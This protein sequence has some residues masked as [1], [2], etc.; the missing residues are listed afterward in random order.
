M[1]KSLKVLMIIILTLIITNFIQAQN[2]KVT[3]TVRDETTGESLIGANI[4]IPDLNIGAVTNTEGFYSIENVKVG[5]YQV[6]VSYIGYLKQNKNIKISGNTKLNFSLEP[7]SVLLDETVVKGTRAVLR[8][9]PVAFSEIKGEELEFRLA[10]RDIPQ[11]LATTPSV[12]S[13]VSGGGAGDANLYV[14]GVSQRNVAVMV[15]GVPVNDMENKWVYWSNWA[16][17]GD[18]LDETQV[19]RGIGASPYSVNAVGGVMNM[20][21]IGVGSEEEYLK[22]RSQYGSN[23]LIKGSLAFHKKLNSLFCD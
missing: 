12:Y 4:F 5:T 15:N 2:Y 16:G 18:V 19:Q 11:E 6:T 14:R 17:L 7:S 3:G 10:S 21:T 13:S 9:T 1:N 8:E 20:T 23:N 22:V